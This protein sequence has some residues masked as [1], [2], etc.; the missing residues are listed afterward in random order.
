MATLDELIV[1]IKADIKDFKSKVGQVSTIAKK[2]SEGM[3][4]AFSKATTAVGNQFNKMREGLNSWQG[5]LGLAAGAAGL[6]LLIKK[7]LDAA[8]EVAKLSS[9]IGVNS[10]LLQELS[11]AA[12]QTGV[13]QNDL[14]A[15]LQRFNR[16]LADAA[17]GSA[18]FKAGFEALG[19]SVTDSNGR[20]RKTEDVLLEVADGVNALGNESD[21]ASALFR[22]FGDAGFK[23]VNLFKGGSA[24]IKAFQEEARKLGLVLDKNALSAAERANDAID[25]FQ[26]T[27]GT[28]LTGVVAE[29][30]EQIEILADA[31]VSLAQGAVTAVNFVTDSFGSIGDAVVA[32]AKKFELLGLK[33]REVDELSKNVSNSN[34][35]QALKAQKLA[36]EN[37]KLAASE[38]SVGQA[39]KKRLALQEEAQAVVDQ[40]QAGGA[41]DQIAREIAAL[42]KA[43]EQKLTIQGD[44]DEALAQKRIEKQELIEEERMAE[45]DRIVEQNE[46]LAELDAERFSAEIAANAAKEAQLRK[47]LE[48]SSKFKMKVAIE[49]EKL[50]N[51]LREQEKANA[52][53]TLDEL[54]TLTRANSKELFA[55]GKAASIAHAIINV[56]EGASEAIAQGGV[57]GP[58]LAA[59]VVAAGA[60]HIANIASQSF[61]ARKGIDEVPGIGTQDNFPAILAPGERVVPRETNQDLKQ[62]LSGGGSGGDQMSVNVEINIAEDA[63]DFIEARLIERGLFNTGL[64][65][66]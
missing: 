54:S 38:D 24:D 5:A 43:K 25:K 63:I 49:E 53:A 7:S 9:N 48:K 29:N 33:Q 1:K 26:K 47:D 52:I 31:L 35:I 41:E 11:F 18:E 19:I 40:V 58:I 28:G 15:S 64:E 39:I 20:L 60:V 59:A 4:S 3:K 14:N 66:S 50:K 55:I 57:F 2:Q 30:A 61:A 56:E 34:S 27:L 32:V 12:S 8:D 16:R 23:L 36:E 22:V 37:E 10:D 65:A 6:G 17:N 46:M 44:L 51:K 42:E 13:A 45:L 62:F 21:Q